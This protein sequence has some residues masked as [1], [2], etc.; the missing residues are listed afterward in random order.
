MVRANCLDNL[1][2]YNMIM[3]SLHSYK[4]QPKDQGLNR[5]DTYFL[6]ANVI[7]EEEGPQE[8]SNS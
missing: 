7:E 2:L 1:N 8:G 3:E 6:S 4:I 5:L